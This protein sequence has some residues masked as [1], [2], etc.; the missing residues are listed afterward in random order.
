MP[1]PADNPITKAKTELGLLLFYDP[2]VSTDREVA[3]VTCHSELWGMS[4]GLPLSVGVDGVGPVGTGR[5]GPNKT[6][7]NSPTLWNSA[8][9]GPVFWDGRAETLEEQVLGPFE[10]PEEL[11]RNVDEVVADL[12]GIPE[13]RDL[14]SAAFPDD[15]EP[16]TV[17]N[18]QKA[19]ATFERTLVSNRAAYDNYVRG[20]EG[21]LGEEA[22][23]GMYLLDELGC[24]SCHVPPL[25]DSPLYEDRRVPAH[26][27]VPDDLGR[28]EATSID[29]DRTRFRVPSLRNLRESAPYFH[30]GTVETLEEAIA[31]EA[32]VDGRTLTE[33]EVR[34][35]AKF[36][37]AGLNDET[38]KPVRPLAVPSGLQVPLDG[39]RIP[40]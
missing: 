1:V 19:V 5:E 33:D 21:A 12:A 13:Y 35:I 9:R 27:D 22:V 32:G 31:H 14:F 23:R 20:D 29:E 10:T 34:A 39:F 36:I 8:W 7:R 38:K 28:F 30:T 16:V 37:V 25:F 24:V 11:G 6:R 18:L 26:P 15:A 2:I 17:I 40:R 3:C 4:D